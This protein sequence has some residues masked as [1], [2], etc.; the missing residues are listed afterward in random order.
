MIKDQDYLKKTASYCINLAKKL[1]ATDVTAVVGHS[2][3]E[4]VN[5]RNRKLDES[6]RSDGLGVG[7]ETYIGKKKS[8]ITSS[9]LNEDNIETLIERCIETTKITPEDEFNSLPDQDL[10]GNKIN[11]LNLYDDDHIEN[12]KKI[13]YLKEAEESALEKKEIIN[14]ETGFTESRSNF[15]LASSDGFLNGYKSSSFSASCVAIAKDANDNMERDYEFTNTCHL[16][17]MLKPNQIGLLAAKK[18]I[19]KLNPQKIESEKISII[20]DRR[21]SKGILSAFASA[22][23]A[24]SVARGTSFLKNKINEEIF[25]TSINIYDKPDIVKGLGSR[26]FDSEGVKT[27]EL[28]LVDKGVLKH[29][30]V[31][32][33]YGKKL[34]LKSNGRSGGT[35]NLFFEKGSISYEDLLKLNSRALYITETIGH[36]SNLVTG[37]YSVGANGFMLENGVFKYPV[38]EITIAGNFK[39]IFKNITLADDLE[40][41]YSTNAPTMLIEGMVV[42][43]K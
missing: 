41:K 31:D 7:L 33:Y 40:F 17:D 29:Y 19:Q 30:L 21:I 3:S 20:F 16:H 6:N 37:D 1:G 25:S 13:E 28:K 10:L 14:T 26:Y 8:G 38:S 15:I 2:I 35:S 24:S 42:A 27:K 36:G 23:T 34:N 43:G 4:T 22:I 39:D 5:F 32:T 18:T 12:D 9:N 11:D